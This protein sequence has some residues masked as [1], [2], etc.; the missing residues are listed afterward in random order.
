MHVIIRTSPYLSTNPPPFGFDKR[1]KIDLVSMCFRSFLPLIK[2]NPITIIN[3][4]WSNKEFNDIYFG[5]N[6]EVIEGDC[7]NVD[8]FYQQLRLEKKDKTVLLLEDDYLWRVDTLE[9]L[10]EAVLSLGF[11]S[12][13]DH[14][15]HHLEAR[16]S[17]LK[18]VV[19]V[20]NYTYHDVPSNTLTFG[21][22]TKLL[23]KHT[24][25]MIKYG[26]RDHELWT[27]IG[28]LYAPNASFATH[29]VKGLLAPNF[30]WEHYT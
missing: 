12:P 3:D 8:T 22:T 25:T 6:C 19:M 2:D 7:G 16:F 23:E 27:E 29:M 10:E 18:R 20:G 17:R 5:I 21:A 13:Y 1:P 24:D 14:P 11:V 15:G 4:G 28:G 30:S 9:P 26:L